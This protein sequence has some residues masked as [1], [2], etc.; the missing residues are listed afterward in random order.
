MSVNYRID[1]LNDLSVTIQALWEHV[2]ARPRHANI[3]ATA[4]YGQTVLGNQVS[5]GFT[6]IKRS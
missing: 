3:M 2:I 1:R 4:L 5:Y 6:L